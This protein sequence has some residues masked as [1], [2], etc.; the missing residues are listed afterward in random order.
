MAT[1]ASAGIVGLV[2]S[3]VGLMVG[4]VASIVGLMV[5]LVASIV[6]LVASVVGLG[7]CIVGLVVGVGGCGNGAWSSRAERDDGGGW[8]RT[9]F[10]CCHFELKRS[11]RYIIMLLFHNY[12]GVI[13]P[14]YSAHYVH[15]LSIAQIDNNVSKKWHWKAQFWTL[16]HTLSVPWTVFNMHAHMVTVQ[17]EIQAKHTSAMWYEEQ[18]ELSYW[19]W[20]KLFFC[21]WLFWVCFFFVVVVFLFCFLFCLL[22]C[23][24]INWW[25]RW[26]N[27]RVLR[28]SHC[29]ILQNA[30][31]CSPQV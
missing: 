3:V 4:L 13:T 28:K 25:S 29:Q 19:F 6:G 15:V 14:A 11:K 18:L 1:V 26:R 8:D 20:H 10:A 12:F 24:P 5:G 17:H 16:Y 9:G 21:W 30:T 2:A 7:A 22:I 23:W 31:N 27:Y